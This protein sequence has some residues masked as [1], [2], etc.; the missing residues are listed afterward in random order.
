MTIRSSATVSPH[1]AP[2]DPAAGE[3][4]AR[5]DRS[6]ADWSAPSTTAQLARRLRAAQPSRIAAR[7]ADDGDEDRISP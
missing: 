6:D 7:S 5:V 4:W 2:G 1:R 3:A